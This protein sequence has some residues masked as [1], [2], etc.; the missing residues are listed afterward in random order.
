MFCPQ[1]ALTIAPAVTAILGYHVG[2]Q[3]RHTE[4]RSQSAALQARRD[5]LAVQAAA[6]PSPAVSRQT[7]ARLAAAQHKLEL[8]KHLQVRPT[9]CMKHMGKRGESMLKQ[10]C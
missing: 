1:A 9:Q 10:H 4:L 5:Q 6:N 3:A 2:L 8:V 7:K